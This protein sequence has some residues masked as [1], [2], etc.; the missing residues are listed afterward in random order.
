[1]SSCELPF[2][3]SEQTSLLW[4][5]MP[6]QSCKGLHTYLVHFMNNSAEISEAVWSLWEIR[7]FFYIRDKF[8]SFNYIK[9]SLLGQLWSRH[10]KMFITEHSIHLIFIYFFNSF[11]TYWSK[12]N[13][14]Y[15]FWYVCLFFLALSLCYYR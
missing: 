8:H 4:L 1:M 14:K 10:C 3:S 6:A 11:L 15:A 12:K 5:Q 13:K 9:E 2:V 7:T